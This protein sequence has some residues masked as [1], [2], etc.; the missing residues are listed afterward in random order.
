MKF[1]V[2]QKRKEQAQ[3]DSYLENH[4]VERAKVMNEEKSVDE[5]KEQI[6]ANK[7]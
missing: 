7:M 6:R 4:P 3:V 1:E 5:V 2:S